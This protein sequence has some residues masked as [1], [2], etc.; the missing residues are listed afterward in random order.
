MPTVRMIRHAESVANAGEVTSDPALI[1][2]TER[3]HEQARQFALTFEQAPDLIVC[4]PFLRVRQTAAPTIARFPS[5]PVEEWPVQEFTYLSPAL[6]AA[7]TVAQRRPLVE[8]YWEKADPA[9]CHG[10]GTESFAAFISRVQAALDRLTALPVASVALFGHGQF[11]QAARWLSLRE[12]S[13][14]LDQEGMRQFRSLDVNA[15]IPNAS[16]FVLQ[17]SYMHITS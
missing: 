1:P 9:F 2:L 10:P 15:T 17:I 7:S 3:G 11:L 8:A 16:A 5:V 6:C 4:S 14:T 12:R 13:T